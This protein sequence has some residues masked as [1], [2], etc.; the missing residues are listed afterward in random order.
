MT[1]RRFIAVISLC[2]LVV[3]GMIGVG[4]VLFFTQSETGQA[5]LRRTIERQVASGIK[6]KLYLGH[7]SGNFLTG[8]AL[9]SM[10]L[11]DDE[12]SLFV[13]TGP[14][15]VGYDVRH[16]L[17]RRLPP[18]MRDVSRPVVVMRQHEDGSWNFKRVFA[19]G[20]PSRPK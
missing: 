14:V 17:G 12:D 16:I 15:R 9:D 6:G 1:R 7:M 20:G 8:I 18:R 4:V 5:A 13:A 2:M 11:R 19:R 10:E 3:L